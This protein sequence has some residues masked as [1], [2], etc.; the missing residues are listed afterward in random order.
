MTMHLA[1]SGSV[2]GHAYRVERS[3]GPRWYVKYRLPDGRQVQRML[4]PAWTR[5][6]RPQAGFWTK[7]LAEAELRRI[8]TEAQNGTLPGMVRTGVTFADATAEWLRYVA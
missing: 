1:R 6:G 7:R 8:L 4:G 2:S 3:R 5:G